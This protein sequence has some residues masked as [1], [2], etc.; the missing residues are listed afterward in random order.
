MKKIANALLAGA[1]ALAAWQPVAAQS[2]AQ[3]LQDLKKE[4]APDKRTAVWEDR[5]SVV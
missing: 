1:M 3:V 5:K 4:I 2:V